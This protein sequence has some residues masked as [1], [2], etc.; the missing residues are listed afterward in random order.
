VLSRRRFLFMLGG[1]AA[2]IWLASTGLIRLERRL[3]LALGG[4]CSFCGKKHREVRTL[5]GTFD[6]P[7]K[8]C[9][10]CVELC[11]SI[12]AEERDW[13][14][15]RRAAPPPPLDAAAD[16]AD[17]TVAETLRRLAEEPGREDSILDDLRRSF[18]PRPR[19]VEEFRC[20]FCDADRRDVEKLIA[21]PRVFIC[22]GC[23]ADAAAVVAHVLRA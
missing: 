5:L 3:V 1:G 18:T 14:S 17:A 10:E 19:V 16:A 2:G 8:I 22:D 6:R 9:D 4:E 7:W 23:S 12:L 15:R 11:T 13:A 20:S 21:G